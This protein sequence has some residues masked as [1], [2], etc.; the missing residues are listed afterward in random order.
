RVAESFA[1]V[2]GAEAAAEVFAVA[3]FGAFPLAGARL[4]AHADGGGDFGLVVVR[5]DHPEPQQPARDDPVGLGL[6]VDNVQPGPA[7]LGRQRLAEKLGGVAA[8]ID[9]ERAVLGVLADGVLVF[10]LVLKRADINPR[11]GDGPG[12]RA[13]AVPGVLRRVRERHAHR[14]ASGAAI[15]RAAGLA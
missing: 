12:V 10:T 1:V 13:N 11:V 5:F 7:E 9:R 15:V 6:V 2:F 8:G 3:G 4:V 14:A